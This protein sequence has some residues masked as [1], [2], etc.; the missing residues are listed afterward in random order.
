MLNMIIAD[1]NFYYAKML[2]NYINEKNDD[3][4]VYGITL[5][6]KETIYLLNNDDKI[7]LFLLDL[8]MPVYTG[9]EV[10]NLLNENKRIKYQNSCIVISGETDMIKEVIGNNIVYS[11]IYKGCNMSKILEKIN[12]LIEYKKEIKKEETI[13]EKITKELRFLHFNESYLGTKYLKESI[14]FIITDLNKNFENLKKEVYPIIAKY[15]Q[16]TIHN[17]KC[18][19]NSSINSM[20]Y[21]CESKIIMEYFSFTTDYKPTTKMIINTIINKIEQE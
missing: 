17:I 2:M 8:N 21:D 6:G 13:K 18:N 10:L 20:Y 9:I 3:V 4:R 19:I 16:K 15:N 1:D 5:D 7:D 12:E 11:I 14:Y